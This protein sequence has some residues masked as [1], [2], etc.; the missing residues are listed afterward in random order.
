MAT[1]LHP[2]QYGAAVV[3]G[4]SFHPEFFGPPPFA[5]GSAAGRRYD[6]VRLARTASPPVAMWLETSHADR[7]SF[8]SSTALLA[9]ERTPMSVHAVILGHAGHRMSVWRALLPDAVAWLGRQVPGVAPTG[10]PVA[11]PAQAKG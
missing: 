2:H 8:S 6:L 11:G 9:A 4:G 5:P 1:M 10:A 7:L 3:M